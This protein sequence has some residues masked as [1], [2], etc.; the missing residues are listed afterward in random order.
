MDDLLSYYG[1]PELAGLVQ[2]LISAT[3]SIDKA[4]ERQEAAIRALAEGWQAI[5]DRRAALSEAAE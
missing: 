3:A 2:E 4:F 5:E 1:Q